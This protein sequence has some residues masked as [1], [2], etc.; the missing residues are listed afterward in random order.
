MI[1]EII[2]ND[3]SSPDVNDCWKVQILS[4][5]YDSINTISRGKRVEMARRVEES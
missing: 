2:F 5:Y 1:I 3:L 4:Q